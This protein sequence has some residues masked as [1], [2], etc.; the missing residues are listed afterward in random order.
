LSSQV[1]DVKEA[2]SYITKPVGYIDQPDFLNTAIS[3]QTNLTPIQ[4]LVFLKKTEKQVGRIKRFKWGPREI[5]IDIIFYGDQI[6][7]EDGVSIPHSCFRERDFVLRP[8]NDLN[9]DF[10]D[11]VTKKTVRELFRSI[12]I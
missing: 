3:G 9:P 8:L 10:I 7:Y 2:P 12:S 4:L 11:P 1:H 6:I 5:D